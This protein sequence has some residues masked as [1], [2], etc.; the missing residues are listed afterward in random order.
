M[1]SY[2]VEFSVVVRGKIALHAE[3]AG[4]AKRLVLYPSDKTVSEFALLNHS[5]HRTLLPPGV[6]NVTEITDG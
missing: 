4:D 6:K 2:E 1:P 5:Y 3:S